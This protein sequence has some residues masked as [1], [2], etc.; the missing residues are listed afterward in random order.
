MDIT[1]DFCAEIVV[2]FRLSGFER[3]YLEWSGVETEADAEHHSA[4][5]TVKRDDAVAA[6]TN[7][8]SEHFAQIETW[9]E[10]DAR[11]YSCM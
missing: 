9:S 5:N 3:R 2:S 6:S 10:A 7:S 4:V 1:D 11:G 8:V